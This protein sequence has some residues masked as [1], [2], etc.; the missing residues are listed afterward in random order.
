MFSG[1]RR[2]ACAQLLQLR[3]GGRHPAAGSPVHHAQL[4]RLLQQCV[5]LRDEAADTDGVCAKDQQRKNRTYYTECG[6][7]G[8]RGRATCLLL[9][10]VTRLDL[11]ADEAGMGR[12]DRAACGT[13]SR[14]ARQRHESNSAGSDTRQRGPP[15]VVA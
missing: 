9:V 4:L 13:R 7:G 14:V 5:R 3:A 1:S 2:R 12:S 6:G 8:Y 15:G 10:A 11:Q